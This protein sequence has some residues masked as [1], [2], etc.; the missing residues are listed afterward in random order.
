MGVKNTDTISDLLMTKN[1]IAITR[2][3]AFFLRC[4]LGEKAPTIT[5]LSQATG[6]SRGTIQNAVRLLEDAG[7]IELSRHGHLGST[8]DKKDVPMLAQL[9]GIRSIVGCMP[10]PY[11]KKYEGMATGLMTSMDNAYGIPASLSYMRGAKNRIR[12]L[13]EGRYD[14]AVVSKYAADQAIEGGSPIEILEEFGIHSYCSAHM[15]LFHDPT[16]REIEDG[17][18][19]GID[20]DSFDQEEMTKLVCQGH[21]VIYVPVEYNSLL[22][23]VKDGSLDATVWNMDE[24]KEHPGTLACVNVSQEEERDTNAVIVVG[25]DRPALNSLLGELIQPETVIQTQEDVILGKMTPSY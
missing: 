15:I 21:D 20:R 8:L 2:I 25:K 14:F 16:K 9:A 6:L 3:S 24:V 17:M 13:T 12:M 10:L 18:R 22:Q 23:R 19:V 7:A 4:R 11:S 1:G 5:E